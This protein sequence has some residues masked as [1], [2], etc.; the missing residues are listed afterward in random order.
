MRVFAPTDRRTDG[1]TD[2]Q[3]KPLIESLFRDLK[4]TFLF[5]DKTDT[6]MIKTFFLLIHFQRLSKNL[7]IQTN[8][9]SVS[10][11]IRS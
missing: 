3:T 9:R 4:R 5:I 7:S 11:T 10:Q 6:K 8:P 1:P 2:G